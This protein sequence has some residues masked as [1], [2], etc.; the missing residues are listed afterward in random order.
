MDHITLR[1]ILEPVNEFGDYEK[2]SQTQS[3]NLGGALRRKGVPD[4][5]SNLINVQYEAFTCRVLHNGAYSDPARVVAVVRQGCIL[6]PLLFVIVIDKTMGGA[7]GHGLILE[8]ISPQNITQI[9][10]HR[11]GWYKSN[12]SHFPYYGCH[13]ESE[14]GNEPQTS[15]I[16]LLLLV[17]AI[18]F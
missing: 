6:S 12:G 3:R 11:W 18:Y 1:M 15:F 14:N 5:I 9:R 4:K 2:S 16:R 7:T 13:G 10:A 8:P 17:Q